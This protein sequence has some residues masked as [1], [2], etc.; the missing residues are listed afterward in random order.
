MQ[1]LRTGQ[2]PGYIR[3]AYIVTT[4]IDS[5]TR[6]LLLEFEETAGSRDDL[7]AFM[8]Y[9]SPAVLSQKIF[10]Q[11]SGSD[12]NRHRR[13]MQSARDMK[14]IFAEKVA[15]TAVAGRKM[16]SKD[17]AEFPAFEHEDLQSGELFRQNIGVLI[18][19]FVIT[20]LMLLVADR[21]LKNLSP[22]HL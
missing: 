10:N 21:R 9:F 13:Y 14:A 19:L 16:L 4:S 8:G 12:S 5:A 3:T 18:Y 2:I 22:A 11:I 7:F 15:P 1:N 17:L 20:L 6:L